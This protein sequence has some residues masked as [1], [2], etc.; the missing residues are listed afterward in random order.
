MAKAKLE[1]TPRPTF[2]PI[3]PADLQ[4]DEE[5][6]PLGSGVYAAVYAA[7]LKQGAGAI[8]QVAVKRFSR[9]SE[10][11]WDDWISPSAE[12]E[13]E[14]LRNLS[15]SNIVA[16]YGSC[17][18]SN[19][20]IGLVME[21]AS[22]SL[23][24]VVKQM[25]HWSVAERANVA[26]ILGP[27]VAAALDHMH[28]AYPA[29]VHQDLK[30][31]NILLMAPS[32]T[33]S[34]AAIPLAAAASSS[35]AASTSPASASSLAWLD[36]LPLHQ[37]GV[38]I[39]DFGLSTTVYKK[40]SEGRTDVAC[41]GAEMG[42]LIYCAPEALDAKAGSASA[43][44]PGTAAGAASAGAAALSQEPFAAR[45]VYALGMVI[46][47]ILLADV[48]W[49]HPKEHHD[50]IKLAFDVRLY[51]ARPRLPNTTHPE[52]AALVN[53][54]WHQDPGKRPTAKHVQKQLEAMQPM[55][56]TA[57]EAA[58]VVRLKRQQEQAA[59]SSDKA[60]AGPGI[61]AGAGAAGKRGC[62]TREL[63]GLV[64][65]WRSS[66]ENKRK[67]SKP[68]AAA[69]DD[70][71]DEEEPLY[72]IVVAGDPEATVMLNVSA[73]SAASSS[74][75]A[76]CA[77]A[78]AMASSSANSAEAV[79]E[80][81]S[82]Q[83][84]SSKGCSLSTDTIAEVRSSMA[85]ALGW[86][87]DEVILHRSDGS[88]MDDASKTLAQCGIKRGGYLKAVRSLWFTVVQSDDDTL[89]SQ[90]NSW[91]FPCDGMRT[92]G[93]TEA[94]ELLEYIA[95]EVGCSVEDISISLP[96]T[97]SSGAGSEGGAGGSYSGGNTARGEM[98][99]MASPLGPT[100]GRCGRNRR[101]PHPSATSAGAQS[102]MQ[103]KPGMTLAAIGIKA[104]TQLILSNM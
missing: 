18:F 22:C 45:D 16:A 61:A 15:H 90:P 101:S 48:P 21:L 30:P 29:V 4:L 83:F 12:R 33:P 89:D 6:G 42:T 9:A 72:T 17:N 64:D 41:I 43:A 71:T 82:W 91:T 35:S 36:Q 2:R 11:A 5:K 7:N 100:K 49:Q 103:L 37:V 95:T 70:E 67:R 23:W 20:D 24:D 57:A 39:T 96:Y 68:A 74:S 56:K 28:N 40:V 54:C 1:S 88:P 66:K 98:S 92:T 73:I 38:R 51:G 34:A 97:S 59:S 13:I 63:A 78:G 55:M 10:T 94:T 53:A 3:N 58:C 99:A 104:G 14:I 62:S 25:K 79:L 77:G 81:E 32:A 44:G 46:A 26:V 80:G 47:S 69:G 85:K 87:A 65:G 31:E 75:F 76:C 50:A 52:L 19:G 93:E 8:Q 102:S 60:E 84:Y 27:K 86:P